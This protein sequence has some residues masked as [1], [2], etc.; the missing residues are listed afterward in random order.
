MTC[1]SSGAGVGV[2]AKTIAEQ[3]PPIGM[4]GGAIT[5]QPEFIRCGAGNRTHR[6]LANR[7]G[8]I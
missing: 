7:K 2:P 3:E 4:G 8:H 1:G 6:S 5:E